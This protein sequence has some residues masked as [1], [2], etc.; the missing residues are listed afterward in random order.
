MRLLVTGAS[1]FTG[2]HLGKLLSQ[3]GVTAYGLASDAEPIEGYAN[4]F[5]ANLLDTDGV[6][7]VVT[8]SNPTHVLHLAAISFVGHADHSEFYTS[9]IVGTVNLLD[10]RH[11]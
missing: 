2:R 10:A 6:A 8:Q 4:V 5:K 7:D 1:G 11:G 9:N 3:K